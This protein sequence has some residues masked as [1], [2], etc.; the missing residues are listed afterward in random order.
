V[1]VLVYTAAEWSAFLEGA[2]KGEFDCQ[3]LWGCTG[4][5]NGMI[6]VRLFVLT[7]GCKP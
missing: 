3:S 2:K 1:A 7:N 4:M 6:C 5:H